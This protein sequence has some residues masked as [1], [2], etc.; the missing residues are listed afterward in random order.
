MRR[1]GPKIRFSVEAL[2]PMNGSQFALLTLV[3]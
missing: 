1:G 3:E 2:A